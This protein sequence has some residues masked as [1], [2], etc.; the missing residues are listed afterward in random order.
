MK[1]EQEALDHGD[2]QKI[3]ELF[4]GTFTTFGNEGQVPSKRYL[5]NGL[6]EIVEADGWLWTLGN[7]PEPDEHLAFG[8][9]LTGG[10]DEECMAKFARALQHPD[11]AKATVEFYATAQSSKQQ[12]TMDEDEMDPK[13][14]ALTGE[15]GE[16]WQ[17]TGLGPTI[18]SALFIDDH[19]VSVVGLYRKNDRPKFNERE[20]MISHLILSGVKWL[21]RSGW[22]E[23]RKAMIPELTL[24]QQTVVAL[25]WLGMSHKKISRVMEI[26]EGTVRKHAQAVYAAFRV[27]DKA[28][29]LAKLAN[30]GWRLP[31]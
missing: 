4:D 21:H 24:K 18:L 3:V 15:L 2:V 27:S 23:D 30:R 13:R 26:A 16:L 19:S 7:H 20:K 22:P 31:E 14:Y 11:S 17:A 6:C 29:L 5:M 1:P 12:V 8:G 10:L 9:F 28:E 25:I